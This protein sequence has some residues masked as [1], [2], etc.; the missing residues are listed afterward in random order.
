MNLVDSSGWLEYFADGKNAKQF[1]RAIEDTDN[2]AVSVI[3]LYE[4]YRK[5]LKEKMKFM[6][7]KQSLL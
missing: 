3:N 2:L 5:V 6:P 1:A 4:I 7:G